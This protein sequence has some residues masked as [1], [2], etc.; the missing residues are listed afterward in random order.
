MAKIEAR[1]YQLLQEL[2]ATNFQRV[3]SAGGGAKNAAWEKIR[4][5]Y[6]GVEMCRPVSVEAAYGSALLAMRGIKN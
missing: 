6:L 4:G 3:Y 1:G 2:G 5:R